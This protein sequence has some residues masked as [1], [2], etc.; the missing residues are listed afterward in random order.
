MKVN[1]AV[2]RFGRKEDGLVTVEWVALAAALVVGA[3]S[4]GWAVLDHMDPAAASVG[5]SVDAV[6]KAGPGSPPTF[7]N[8]QIN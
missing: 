2:R 5:T 8:G 6:A 3:I 7:G 4:I 1:K